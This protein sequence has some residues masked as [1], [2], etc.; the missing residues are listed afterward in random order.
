MVR[1]AEISRLAYRFGVPIQKDYVITGV[2]REPVPLMSTCGLRF[3][4]GT[5]LKKCYFPEY[6]FSEDLDFTLE[7][8][9]PVEEACASLQGVADSFR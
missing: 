5:C 4:G 1:R 7:D 8:G 6:R 2:L 9:A 3:K